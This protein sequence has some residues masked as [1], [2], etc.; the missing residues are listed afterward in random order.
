MSIMTLVGAGRTHHLT[1]VMLPLAV[2]LLLCKPQQTPAHAP[3]FLCSTP[4]TEEYKSFSLAVLS[5]VAEVSRYGTL[6]FSHGPQ[7][8]MIEWERHCFPKDVYLET[9]AL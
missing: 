4:G 6:S 9:R 1:E 8:R 7:S 3:P 2:G 5:V